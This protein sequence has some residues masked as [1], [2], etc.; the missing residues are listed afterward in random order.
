V[1]ASLCRLE[2]GV[3]HT[4]LSVIAHIQQKFNPL[5]TPTKICKK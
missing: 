5:R 1:G 2:T 3:G 4:N